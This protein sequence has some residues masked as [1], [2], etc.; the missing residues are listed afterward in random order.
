MFVANQVCSDL[1][2]RLV[3][4]RPSLGEA[5]RIKVNDEN[6]FS[7]V[8]QRILNHSMKKGE[9][10]KFLDMTNKTL[11]TKIEQY[12]QSNEHQIEPIVIA[13]SHYYSRHDIASLR[14][15]MGVE[16][17]YSDLYSSKLIAI[18]NHKGGTGKSSTTMTLAVG[19][20]LDLIDSQRVLVI[21][22]D[23]Q[24]SVG[25]TLTFN[26]AE[27]KDE[28]I[29]TFIDILLRNFEDDNPVKT[30]LDNGHTLEEIIL[31]VMFN[32]HLPN[33][34][35]LIAYP[36]DDRL[37]GVFFNLEDEQKLALICD[38]RDN[39]KPILNKH[40]DTV[41]ID[42]PPADNAILWCLFEAVDALLVPITP[43]FIDLASTTNFMGTL[44]TRLEQLPSHGT[45]IKWLKAA[46]VNHDPKSREEKDIV[47]RL[48]RS[49]QDRLI[50]N[51][52]NR[53]EAFLEAA[54]TGRTVLDLVQSRSKT[55]KTEFHKAISSSEAFVNTFKIEMQTLNL[56]K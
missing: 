2:G 48:C 56:E 27:Q 49:V 36:T 39:I 16:Q 46:V 18:T 32:T 17:Y 31:A 30:F 3:K 50:S 1:Y 11:S 54:S 21:D 15:F 38:F 20:A 51:Y 34:K 55:S 47:G 12:N 19:L 23:P 14:E 7:G 4:E 6:L 45:N 13:K 9:L 52:I 25:S 24:G 33:L 8:D 41:L 40:F 5:L 22:M 26:S 10:S 44:A 35:T 43:K 42:T 29:I 28:E 37:V 53:S